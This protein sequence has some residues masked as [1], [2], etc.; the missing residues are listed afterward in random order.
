MTKKV[1]ENFKRVDELFDK[2]ASKNKQELESAKIKPISDVFPLAQNGIC[3][4]IAGMGCGKSYNYLKLAA[5]Q[6]DLY[7]EPFFETIVICSTSGDFDKT[8]LTFKHA[9]QKSNLIAVKDND[10]M[11]FIE[12]HTK[13]TMLY[14]TLMKFIK[15]N[16]KRP[17][18]EMQQIIQENRLQKKEKLIEYIGK[19]FTEIGWK[20]YPSRLLLIFDDFSSHPLLKS[21][22]EPLSRMLKKLRHFNINVIICVQTVK[23]IP[24]DIKRNLSDLIV[25]PGISED[26]FKYL[27]RESS[28]S[29]FNYQVLWKEYSKIKDRQTMF[30]M[31]IAARRV[32]V[33]PPKNFI[34]RYQRS[35]NQP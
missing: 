17:S 7:V 18:E 20:T 2:L 5:K 27:I 14:N 13:K 16:F 10:L 1:L 4:F 9:I 30:A 35:P 25:F 28:A 19:K 31:H 26:D 21:R 3:A 33:T 29:C 15:S 6:E 11:N 34:V 23:S 12:E 22:D 32:I 8:V 24:K